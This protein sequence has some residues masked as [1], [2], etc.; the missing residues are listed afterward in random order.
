MASALPAPA[1]GSGTDVFEAEDDAERSDSLNASPNASETTVKNTTTPTTAPMIEMITAAILV[2]LALPLR[3][4][5]TM[6]STNATGR[7]T[8]PTMSAP[9]MQA[10]TKPMMLATRAM[11]PMVLVCLTGDVGA[12]V[13]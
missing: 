5:P 3:K 9:G 7:R 6:P 4:S 11:V 12:G 2:P 1:D 13:R 8:H 10:K